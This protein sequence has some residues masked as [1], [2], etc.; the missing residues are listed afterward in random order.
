VNVTL[1]GE[2]GGGGDIPLSKIITIKYIPLTNL[3]AKQVENPRGEQYTT[4]YTTFNVAV[5]GIYTIEYTLTY[6]PR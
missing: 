3:Y 6:V 5:G 4:Y 1:N 2:R